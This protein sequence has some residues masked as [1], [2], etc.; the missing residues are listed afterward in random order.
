MGRGLGASGALSTVVAVG[1]QTIA[2]EHAA[3]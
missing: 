3:E 2:P 1:V